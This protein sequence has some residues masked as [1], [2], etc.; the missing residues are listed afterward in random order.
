[1]PANISLVGHSSGY[2]PAQS[3]TLLRP[4]HPGNQ[5][6]PVLRHWAANITSHHQHLGGPQDSGAAH[7]LARAAAGVIPGVIQGVLTPT[8]GRT[9][10]RAQG[11]LLIIT[12]I[13]S[14]LVEVPVHIVWRGNVLCQAQQAPE[15]MRRLTCQGIW[16]G[17]ALLLLPPTAEGAGREVQHHVS[18]V[19]Q[20]MPMASQS[21]LQLLP[22]CI[23]QQLCLH[24]RCQA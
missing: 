13:A 18:A 12:G 23:P 24:N 17:P 9:S 8:K 15:L 6:H 21:P 5:L 7:R 16:L 19:L 22:V 2:Q 20:V 1:V 4:T 10:V 14:C 11:M 3:V